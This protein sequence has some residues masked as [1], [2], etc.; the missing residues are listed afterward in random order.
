MDKLIEK[1]RL[2]K[3]TL[4]K[5]HSNSRFKRNKILKG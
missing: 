4:S 2:K 1:N 3:I 5:F